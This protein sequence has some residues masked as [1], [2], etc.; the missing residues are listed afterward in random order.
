MT[1]PTPH[2]LPSPGDPGALARL[3]GLLAAA[4]AVRAGG[5]LQPLLEATARAISVSLGFG[6]VAVN[7]HRPAW[8]DFEVVAV[9]GREEARSV[10]LGT[11]RSWHSWQELLHP[12]FERGGTYLIPHGEFDWDVEGS[13]SYVPPAQ[14]PLRPDDWHPEDALLVPL[15]SSR[16]QL[17]GIVSVDEPLDGRRPSDAQLDVLSA[18]A[19]HAALAV[20]HAQ[21]SAQADRNRA[22]VQH[23][24]RVSARLTSR[25]SVE[26]MLLAVCEGIREA[27]GFQRVIV[28]LTEGPDRRLVQRSSIGWTAEELAELPPVP[29]SSI[30]R[31]L[32][33]EHQRE[34]CVLLAREEAE[35]LT[36]PELHRAQR[37]R[38]N[39][40]GPLAWRHHWLIVPLHDRDG[41]FTGIVWADEPEDRLL[42]TTERLQALR[43]FANQASAALES[44]RQ[45]AHMRH[46]AEHDPLTGL[47]NRRE[48]EPRL[49]EAIAR[50][51]P[52]GSVSVLL[53]DLDDFRRVND[54]LG[55][56][57]G[58]DV[59][60]RFA[61]VLR[62]STRGSDVPTRLDAE[63]FAVVLR[64]T[65]RATALTV[66]DRLRQ[67]VREE[68]ADLPVALSVSIG[69]AASGTDLESAPD[70][71]SAAKRALDA[72]KRLG[73]DRTA[74]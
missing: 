34:G 59:L 2:S 12:R 72:A 5:D 39:G 44:A 66:A 11:S 51:A 57:A 43:A 42:P 47:R 8:D 25:R 21:S 30:S 17:L 20:E 70:L 48:L 29:V 37:G 15:R 67:A 63:Q 52:S 65:D 61:D 1:S 31:L 68:F 13:V 32:R 4:Q 50:S 46:L 74:P 10:L 53:C 56:E 73:P 58:E 26:E 6:T 60:R 40:R 54:R 23:L 71:L 28:A 64:D 41:A 19:G 36:P 62:H 7:L 33:A 35:A 16:G 18:V 38:R 49:L 27:L 69:L 55:Q 14:A 22:A 45:L 3:R 24:Q 9:H